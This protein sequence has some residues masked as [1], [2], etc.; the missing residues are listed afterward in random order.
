MKFIQGQNRQQ[1]YLFPVSLDDAVEAEN[2]VR[3]I[4]VFVDSLK[5]E[6]YGFKSDY[7]ENGRPAY[8][9]SD[10][11]RLFIYGYL[12]RI[13]SSRQLE[14]ECKRNIEV[15]WLVKNL[16]PDHNTISNFRRDNPKAIKKVFRETVKIAQYFNLIGGTLLAGDST[17]LRAQNSKKN[18]FN[19]KKIDRHLEYIEN[20]LAEY[21][22]ALAENDGDKEKI[23]QE[24]KK[25]NQRK[26]GYKKL[27]KQLKESGQN[28]IST[29][30]PDSRH[31]ITRNN[32]TEVSYSAQ[33]TVDEKNN[34]PIDYKI[35]NANDKKAM[36]NML[37][38]AKSILRHNHFT[39][40]YDKGYHT[41]SELAIADALDIPAIVA[42]PPFSGASHAPDLKYDVEH[43]DY[44]P[45]TD[46][47]TCPQGHTLNTTG[48]WHE[49]KN[50]AGEVSYRFRNYTTPQCKTCEVHP[51]CTKSAA[52]GKQVRRSEYADNIEN[53]KKRVLNSERLYKRRQAIVEHPFGTI[54]RQW[55]FSYII[56]KKYIER[57]EADFGLTMVAYNLRRII[58]I[59]GMKELQSYLAGI[60]SFLFIKF[61]RFKLILSH[62]DQL[63]EKI[64]KEPK[65]KT[66]KIINRRLTQNIMI[67]KSF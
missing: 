58:N 37:Q 34:I 42:I 57:A 52:N 8:H 16:C 54:K 4:D 21:E 20:K 15:I 60:F 35:T 67:H 22:E 53:N 30:D 41:G 12:N 25:Q 1:T 32:I 63:I 29:S 64:R 55:G 62:L 61:A 56:T 27:E 23:E 5:L 24:I 13:R 14:K 17:K 39:A 47:Y 11:L 59:I 33:T 48:T 19:Q 49:T 31:Q 9:P 65:I 51:L 7:I 40:L 38:R 28:Q 44:D 50:S 45:E 43:F 3:L 2:E 18:N 66:R 10:L 36:G 46:T 26:E 6:E